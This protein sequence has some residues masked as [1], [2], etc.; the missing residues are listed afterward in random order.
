VLGL[1]AVALVVADNQV[2]GAQAAADAGC[3]LVVDA[4]G[5]DVSA[6]V[7]DEVATLLA[8]PVQRAAMAAAGRS[9]CDGEG[10]ARVA[11]AVVALATA[12]PGPQE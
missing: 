7:L 1:P 6:A 9:V 3:A 2:P 11:E 5:G 4:R 8:D 12:I 10:A